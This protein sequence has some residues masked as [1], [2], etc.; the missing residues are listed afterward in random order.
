MYRQILAEVA[1]ARRWEVRLYDAKRVIGRASDMLGER[2]E[3]IL[4][5]PPAKLGPPWTQDHRTGPRR[6]DRRH[7][8][9]CSLGASATR[10]R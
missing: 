6:D 8:L 3:Q 4:Q 1:Q 5:G 9:I 7:T 2:A 10:S